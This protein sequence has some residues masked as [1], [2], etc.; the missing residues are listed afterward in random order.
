MNNSRFHFSPQ[1]SEVDS[2]APSSTDLP[3]HILQLARTVAPLPIVQAF[4]QRLTESGAPYAPDER[5][6]VA[7]ALHAY[8]VGSAI[9]TGW[10]DDKGTLSTGML[11]DLA[12]LADDPHEVPV[13]RIGAIEVVATVVGGTF[14]H[15]GF[16]E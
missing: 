13:E 2:I 16:D 14:V 11:A 15:G 9:A 7:Q 5:L 8:T 10:A 12:V 4:V 6:S 1:T 3:D